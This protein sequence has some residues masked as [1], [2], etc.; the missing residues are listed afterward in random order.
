MVLDEDT[1]LSDFSLRSEAELIEIRDQARQVVFGLVKRISA[2]SQSTDFD[3]ESAQVVLRVANS[4][5]S[6][7]A[8]GDGA[9]DAISLRPTMG[10]QVRFSGAYL[11][12]P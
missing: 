7:R 9:T 4:V 2:L 3:P 11:S 1:I 8:A 12:A 5:L 6:S 10:H